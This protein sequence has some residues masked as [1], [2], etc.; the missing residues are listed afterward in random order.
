MSNDKVELY[1]SLLGGIQW[2]L[3]NHTKINTESFSSF[4]NI[5]RYVS[6][7]YIDELFRLGN[8]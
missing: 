7:T 5:T 4:A 2:P 1:P 6:G 3:N 8:M